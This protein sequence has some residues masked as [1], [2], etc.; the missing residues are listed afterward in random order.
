MG[1][2]TRNK[3]GKLKKNIVGWRCNSI[4]LRFEFGG[5][6]LDRFF[7]SDLLKRIFCHLFLPLSGRPVLEADLAE[8]FPPEMTAISTSSVKEGRDLTIKRRTWRE[9][10]R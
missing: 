7:F 3:L 1:S 2:Y 6:F 5:Y 10:R 9:A 4:L 8:L